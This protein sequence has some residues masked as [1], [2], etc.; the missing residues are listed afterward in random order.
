M[1]WSWLG[2]CLLLACATSQSTPM[3]EVG[4]SLVLA[5]QPAEVH[6]VQEGNISVRLINYSSG[7]LFVF[8][9]RNLSE[10]PIIVD[11][12]AVEMVLPGGAHKRRLPG[13]LASAY[14]IKP[15]EIHRVN[16]KFDVS[17]L[18]AT[19]IVRFDFTPALQLIGGARLQMPPIVVRYIRS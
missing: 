14:S 16:V 12:D 19:D 10:M 9:V 3:V 17:E 6:E 7:N 2:A 11:R 5:G 4:D 8:E 15:A 13:G 1:R 18:Q